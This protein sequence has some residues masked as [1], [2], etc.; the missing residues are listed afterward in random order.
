MEMEEVLLAKIVVAG[1]IVSSTV[2][3]F[4]LGRQLLDDGFHYQVTVPQ[5]L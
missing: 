5:I 1:Q 3:Q 4:P 2:E